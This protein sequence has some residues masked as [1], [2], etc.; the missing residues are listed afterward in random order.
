MENDAQLNKVLALP[1]Q[2]LSALEAVVQYTGTLQQA[3]IDKALA[4]A[5]TSGL[6]TPR[7]LTVHCLQSYCSLNRTVFRT[8]NRTVHGTNNCTVCVLNWTFLWSG[9]SSCRSGKMCRTVSWSHAW[10][11]KRP[12]NARVSCTLCAEYPYMYSTCMIHVAYRLYC[13]FL[14]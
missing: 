6:A 10:V 4:A 3:T 7:F 1:A 2:C 11:L 13:S 5:K 12:T 9:R 8:K 14:H